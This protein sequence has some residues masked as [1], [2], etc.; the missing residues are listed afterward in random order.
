MMIKQ[1]V[2]LL[3]LVVPIAAGAAHAQDGEAPQ[4]KPLAARYETVGVDRAGRVTQKSDWYLVRTAS[5]IETAAE[6]RAEIWERS[7]R[8]DVSMRRVLRDDQFILE[9]HPG[10]LRAMSI[11][12]QW[13]ALGTVVDPHELP[14]LTRA[15]SKKALGRTAQVYRSRAGR[16]RVEVWWIQDVSL[17]ALVKRSGE[18][19]TYT[20]KLVDVRESAPS[21]WPLASHWRT[22]EFRVVDAA[23]LG[24]LEHDPVVK[25]IM[26]AD[27][28]RQ[29][30]FAP[31]HAHD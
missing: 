18:L 19:G 11:E 12:P 26:R 31:A 22:E 4:D 6:G 29:V 14:K 30:R 10:D 5:R 8:G 24:D 27:A 13:R 2:V 25:R 1:T 15:G 17:P 7:E 20:M 16:D 3:W 28:A 9:Y 21:D 23:D